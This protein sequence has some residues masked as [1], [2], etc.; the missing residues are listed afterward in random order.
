MSNIK[1]QKHVELLRILE[2]LIETIELM[3]ENEKDYL[4]IQH[5]NEAVEWLSFLKTHIDKEE[6]KS[7]ENEI[8]NRFFMRYDVQI[9]ET[10]LDNKRTELIKE[11][12]FKSNKYLN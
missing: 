4:L 10:K 2:K 1:K 11:Y 8:A 9:S 5:R 3:L 6:L 12:L 7:L